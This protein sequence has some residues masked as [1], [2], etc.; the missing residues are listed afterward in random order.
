VL[1]AP[2]A[3]TPTTGKDIVP[4]G[5]DGASK[6]DAQINGGFS[7]LRNGPSGAISD[8]S[9]R[10]RKQDEGGN[11]RQE[12]SNSAAEGE[13]WLH[14]TWWWCSAGHFWSWDVSHGG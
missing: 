7:S 14:A 11:N 2:G 5:H 6:K 8:S 4:S 1:I 12:Q 13:A 10:P 9:N 3:G